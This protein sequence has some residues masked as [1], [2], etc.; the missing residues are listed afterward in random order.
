MP[1]I[2]FDRDGIEVERGLL[3]L[4]ATRPKP[5]GVITHAHGDHVA[6][7]RAAICTNPTAALVSLR[8]GPGTE[9]LTLRFGETTPVGDLQVTLL[10][11]GHILGSAMV[12]LD[13][14][15]GESLLYT[16][17][18]KLEG[19]L[20]SP[21][22]EPQKVDVLVTEATFGKPGLDLPDPES[23]RAELVEFARSSIDEGHT[24]VLLAYALGKAQEVASAL[25][26]AGIPVRVHGTAWN[27]CRVYRDQGIR[28]PGA[29]RLSRSE[30]PRR[31][32]A[33]IVPP[34]FRNAPEIR[35]CAP[36]RM[37]AV[38]GWSQR[39][40]G[41]GIETV[42]PLSDHSD[43]TGLLRLVE[44]CDPSKVYVV[45]GYAQEFAAALRERGFD[46]EAVAGHAGPPDDGSAPG[47]FAPR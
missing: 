10:P 36:L 9:F 29:R 2:R 40:L 8:A 33:I 34:R 5:L 25:C 7:H 22:A 43:F 26:G 41:D 21:P 44:Q 30:A 42:I 15:G 11:A 27:L 38:T 18:V 20:T 17:D 31:D 46:A 39:V 3:W 6:R 47:M 35:A 14:P 24:P 1:R 23:A 28:F 13:G 32:A 45:H 16:G 12:R 19:G 37:A 4:D